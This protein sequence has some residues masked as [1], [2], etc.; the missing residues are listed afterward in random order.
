MAI[1]LITGMSGTGKTTI[2]EELARRG[3]RTVETDDPGWIVETWLPEIRAM[4]R[5]WIPERIEALLDGH[6]DG[7]V[8]IQGTV[9]NQRAF[10]PRFDAVVLLSA[11]LE[12]ML[13]RIESRTNNPFGKNEEERYRIV[14]D[15]A[16]IEPLLRASAT[17]E[18]DTSIPVDEVADRLEAIASG[19]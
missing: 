18:I 19:R 6:A 13:E 9:R 15:R 1:I 2:L 14:E 8:F 10:Y 4:E 7:H 16:T 17:H 11:P 12:T 3:H 5:L